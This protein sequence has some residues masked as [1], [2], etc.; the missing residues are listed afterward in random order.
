M[1][2]YV[3]VSLLIFLFLLINFRESFSFRDCINIIYPKEISTLNLKEYLINN[4]YY[5]L[6]E[7]CYDE[8]C[9]K[10]DT[11]NINDIVNNYE[12]IFRDSIDIDADLIYRVKGYPVNMIKLNS[13]L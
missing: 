5:D 8:I 9:Y 6:V 12:M 11:S 13:C 4:G 3:V 7:I 2:K 1:K 10:V